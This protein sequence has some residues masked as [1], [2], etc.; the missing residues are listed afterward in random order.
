MLKLADILDKVQT[1][2]PG[3]DV[4]L[5]KK[6]YVFASTSHEGQMRRSGEPYI[7]HPLAVAD[8]ICD[9]KLDTSSI[10]AAL[11]HDTV[12]DTQATY[13]DVQLLFNKEIADLVDGVTKLG[14][15]RFRNKAERQAESFRKMLVAMSKDIRVILVKLCDRLHN[16]RTLGHVP[17]TKAAGI[18]SE[19]QDIYAPL[20][21]RLG[22]QWVKTELEDLSFRYLN[23]EA[24]QHVRA[25]V[26]EKRSEREAY[27]GEVIGLLRAAMDE[28][29]VEVEVTGRPK[30][31]FSIHRKMRAQNI[32]YEQV[33]DS[34]AF[35]ILTSDIRSC[36]Q[37]L[38]VIHSK[39]RPIPG[40]FKDYVAL[41]KPN[42]YQSLHTAVM[43]PGGRRME[44]QIRT[45]EMHTVAECG[46][47][48][49]WKYK[50]GDA[51]VS[52]D[53]EQK[54]AWLRQLL[55]WQRELDDPTDFFDAVKLDLFN[56]EVYVFTPKGDLKVLPKGSTPVDFAYAIHSEVGA[57]CSGA[58]VNN[59]MVP[60]DH[61]LRSGDTCDIMTKKS[62]RP[63]LD[64][65]KFVRTARAKSRVRQYVRLEQR[66][67]SR[68]VGREVL[69]K[70][71]RRYKRS[72]NKELKSGRLEAVAKGPL[73]LNSTEELFV[74]LGYGKLQLDPVVSHLVPEEDRD[75]FAGREEG[76]ISK[77][78]RSMVGGKS[79]IRVDGLDD[80][81]VRFAKC[82]NPVPG[83][84]ITGFVTRG[85]GVTIHTR[86]CRHIGDADP[87]R[88]LEV[89]W[90]GNV[91]T[92]VPITVSVTCANNPGL[93]ASI[94]QSFH[95]FGINIQEAHC[96]A[97]TDHAVNTFEVMVEGADQLRSVMRAIAAIAG[98]HSVDR[99]RN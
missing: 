67:R 73:K 77:M 89:Y 64:W 70:A 6:A 63:N 8:L 7:T 71:L 36:Y 18:A 11:L 50:E 66:T 4:D 45:H 81:V 82:C 51:G 34:I 65:L 49:H 86:D 90:D 29:G 80:V 12:E 58:L 75:R 15:L 52:S 16:M 98:V 37:A 13:Q 39:W 97:N 46:I 40:R 74:L 24:Y 91:K 53:D 17:D 94:S 21:N 33:Y 25:K 10:C 20:A 19:T 57:R 22:I 44:V 23:P 95:E 9:L 43:G 31:F 47:A 92:R 56:A 35:R 88:R 38:G 59:V 3:A 69:E 78:F 41:P 93:L 26:N 72:V 84:P 83:D 85:R 68:E 79:G 55:E 5:I 1:Y 42:R 54:F 28:S 99:V 60:L 61:Q 62:Q 32:E 48:A 87:D 30:H 27:I 14:K 76:R 96:R 2:Q